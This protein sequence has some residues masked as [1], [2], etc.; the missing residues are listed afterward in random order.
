MQIIQLI[1]ENIADIDKNC[2]FDALV[3][4]KEMGDAF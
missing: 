2:R 1:I 4:V 3:I